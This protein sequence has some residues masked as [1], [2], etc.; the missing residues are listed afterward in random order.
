LIFSL[1]LPFSTLLPHLFEQVFGDAFS[2]GFFNDSTES[3][4]LPDQMIPAA[5]RRRVKSVEGGVDGLGRRDLIGNILVTNDICTMFR[6]AS[7]RDLSVLA[8]IVDK[9]LTSHPLR[10]H[11]WKRPFR[12][13]IWEIHCLS[14]G[15]AVE[16]DLEG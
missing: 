9:I 4:G 13:K 1:N 10:N 5:P 12:R 7:T 6:V 16:S 3:F 14:M 15:P 2:E 11:S 8:N